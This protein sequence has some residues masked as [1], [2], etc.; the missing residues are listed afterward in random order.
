M[1]F[2]IYTIRHSHIYLCDIL[3][4]SATSIWEHLPEILTTDLLIY[5]GMYKI[6][7]IF[8][9][10]VLDIE[11]ILLQKREERNIPD[12][13]FYDGTQQPRHGELDLSTWRPFNNILSFETFMYIPLWSNI[14]L[15]NLNW[16][17]F[18]WVHYYDI[19]FVLKIRM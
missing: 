15:F 7:T 10:F 13:L 8:S 6:G 2:K 1:H 12:I 18:G 4:R 5:H 17:I 14:Y 19:F 16:L 3:S 11:N 9:Y